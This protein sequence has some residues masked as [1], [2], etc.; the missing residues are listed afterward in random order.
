MEYKLLNGE[1]WSS[2]ELLLRMNDDDFY[3]NFL[4]ENALSSSTCKDLLRGVKYYE[5]NKRKPKSSQALTDGR[6]IHLAALEPHRMEEL[7]T[8]DASS[9]RV[10]KFLD[11]KK[12][13][14]DVYLRSEVLNAS[15]IAEGLLRNDKVS[16]ILENSQKE[17]SYFGTYRDLPFRVKVDIDNGDRIV[18][19]KTTSDI[20]GFR[21]DAKKYD[22]DLQAALYLEI[23]GKSTFD[24]LV[25]DKKTGEIGYWTTSEEFIQSGYNKL[26]KAIDTFILS[27][28]AEYDPYQEMSEGEL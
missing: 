26:D 20:S 15:S 24:F 1:V 9:R 16:S 10:K 3:Y 4:G 25:L 19:L 14:G 13:Y 28:D 23:T 17:V 22:Y 5:H 18:D 2:D 7:Q 12:E 27:R 21:W 8:I 11:F 6:L